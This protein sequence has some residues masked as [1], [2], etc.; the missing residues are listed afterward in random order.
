MIKVDV[1]CEAEHLPRLKLLQTH[2]L[3]LNV[4]LQIHEDVPEICSDRLLIVPKKRNSRLAKLTVPDD[5][6]RI[7]LFLDEQSEPI[8]ADM[9]VT[10]HSWPARSSD[11]HVETLARHLHSNRNTLSDEDIRDSSAAD[12]QASSHHP[13]TGLSSALKAKRAERRKNVLT[14]TLLGVG[15]VALVSLLESEP[16]QIEEQ[17]EAEIEQLTIPEQTD[18]VE[19][20]LIADIKEKAGEESASGQLAASSKSTRRS[21]EQ[22][23]P[24]VVIF[25]ETGAQVSQTGVPRLCSMQELEKGLPSESCRLILF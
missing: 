4:E 19:A 1:V 22:Y 13:T 12:Q 2:M 6:E 25:D 10:L 9:Q 8:E 20:P 16:K 18:A 3:G 21:Q 24:E 11:R 17:T 14:L 23:S 7:A 5:C 15:V